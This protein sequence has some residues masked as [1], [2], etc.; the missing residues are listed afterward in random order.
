MAVQ[1]SDYFIVERGGVVYNTLA[2]DILAYMQANLGTTEYDVADIAARNALTGT[3]TGDRVFVADASAD[4]TVTSGWAIYV[5]RGAGWTK[6]A[7]AEGL[8]VVAGGAD[9][10]YT[11]SSTQ[12]VVVS[13]SG[14]DA[15]IPAANGT[16]AG[17]MLPAHFTK[18]G[19]VTVTAATD[20]D[21]IRTASHAA[22]SL[23]GTTNTNPLTLSGQALGFSI[24]QL[25]AAP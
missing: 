2:S 12:G 19:N 1:G 10:S 24:S 6:V 18:L 14:D 3:T 11:A 4:A 9:L 22:A 25:T 13:S 8:D 21:A 7:E 20:L 16:N 23:A 5:W 15:T 17:L